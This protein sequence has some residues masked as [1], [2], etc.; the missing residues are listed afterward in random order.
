VFGYGGNPRKDGRAGRHLAAAQ[1]RASTADAGGG[2][3]VA[4]LLS[5]RAHRPRGREQTGNALFYRQF[6]TEMSIM[7]LRKRHE[8]ILVLAM[9]S[10][11]VFSSSASSRTWKPTPTQVAGD[12]ASIMHTRGNGDFAKIYGGRCDD[13]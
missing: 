13:D 11:V 10:C 2:G 6:G 5:C 9:L 4:A 7:S 8:M 1:R 12:Y 3:K